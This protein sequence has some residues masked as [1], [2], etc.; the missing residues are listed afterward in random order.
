MFTIDLLKGQGIP[1]KAKPEDIAIVAAIFTVP[2][3]I[4]IVMFGFYLIN[5]VAISIQKQEI[6]NYEAKI[7]GLSDAVKLQKSLENEKNAVISSLAE[8]RS[9]I[10]RH[11]QW[12]PVL[13]TLVKNMPDSVILT[14][15]ELKQ[16][17][18][19]REVPAKNDPKNI[20]I[21]TV[22]VRTLRMRVSGSPQSN[23]DKAIRDFRDSLRFSTLLGP[24]LEDI[25]VSQEFATLGDQDVVSYEIDC[26]FKPGL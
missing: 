7:A 12:S 23:C 20:T 6:I 11:T 26:I 25:K 1:V 16:H 2:V 8:V 24:K 5:S 10:G 19:R 9:S 15:L 3:I 14:E 4:T 17:S 18:I 21:I 22:P 13:A